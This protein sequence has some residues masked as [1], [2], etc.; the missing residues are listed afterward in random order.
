MPEEL[1]QLSFV[2][3]QDKYKKL[4]KLADEKLLSIPELVAEILTDVIAARPE[5]NEC[6]GEPA[7]ERDQNG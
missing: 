1:K 7:D 3:A 5:V 2:I 4:Q 6:P